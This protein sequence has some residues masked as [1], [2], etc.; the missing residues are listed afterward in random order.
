MPSR[1]LR[2]LKGARASLAAKNKVSRLRRNDSKVNHFASL[3]MTF[4]LRTATPRGKKSRAALDGQP[5]A[6]VPARSLIQH[7]LLKPSV[8]LLPG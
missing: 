5:G 8:F 1:R 6:A 2:S 7:T 3:E 4:C